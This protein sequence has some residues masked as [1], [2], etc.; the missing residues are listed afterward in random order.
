MLY[1]TLVTAADSEWWQ[2]ILCTDRTV[3]TPYK[4]LWLKKGAI[5]EYSGFKTAQPL[6]PWNKNE[7]I[8]FQNLSK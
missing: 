3:T 7:K 5:R 4:Q 2:Q 1:S 6:S 8:L